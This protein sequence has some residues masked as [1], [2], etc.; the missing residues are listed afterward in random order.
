MVVAIK[1]KRRSKFWTIARE[2]LVEAAV[3]SRSISELISKLGMKDKSSV[4]YRTIK[5]RLDF[6]GIDY[7]HIKLGIGA[8][9]GR[10]FY[11]K[12]KI[13]L[14]NILIENSNYSR[15]H[16]KTR[17]IREG[18]LE[19]KCI[20]CGQLPEWNN[21]PLT[22]QIDHINGI[23]NDNRLENLRIICPHC[24]SQT[25]NF[26]GRNTKRTKRIKIENEKFSRRKVVRP[27]SEELRNMVWSEPTVLIAKRFGVSDSA[28]AKWV[29]DYGLK[30]PPRGYWA[31]AKYNIER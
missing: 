9:K 29:K 2:Y 12:T 15:V 27:S 7:S 14:E 11:S 30:K 5:L 20:I 25:E 19:N 8:N 18:F 24:H 28:I 16:L 1:R 21:K 23:A 31:K 10:T 22:L 4:S 13:P 17:L 3:N 6:E 26:A